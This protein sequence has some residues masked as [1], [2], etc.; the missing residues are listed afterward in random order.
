M[1]KKNDTQYFNKG[2]AASS[3]EMTETGAQLGI[4]YLFIEYLSKNL[5]A[6]FFCIFSSSCT[7]MGNFARN[8]RNWIF[9]FWS[10]QIN[11]S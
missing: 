11:W 3:I 9:V 6:Y 8:Y 1:A 2:I 10:V 4:E 7:K 5:N